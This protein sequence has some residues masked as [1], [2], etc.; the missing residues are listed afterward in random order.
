M[1][2]H[3]DAPTGFAW[4]RNSLRDGTLACAANGSYNLAFSELS[5]AGFVLLCT[6]SGHYVSGN[7]FEVSSALS[8]FRGE[9]LRLLAIF[10]ILLAVEEYYH[11]LSAHTN[12]IIC[13]NKAAIYRCRRRTQQIT[14]GQ[15]NAD[16]LCVHHTITNCLH[17]MHT[18]KHA[19]AH[20]NDHTQFA[21]LTLT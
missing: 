17:N 10:L 21:N 19:H 2:T 15:K 5:G 4:L 8:S 13:D 16:I 12:Q 20:Q 14:P 9:L 3:L 18:I 7:F 6:C 11:Q 1:W